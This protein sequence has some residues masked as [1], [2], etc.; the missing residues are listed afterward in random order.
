MDNVSVFT[1]R[2]MQQ[3]LLVTTVRVPGAKDLQVVVGSSHV[4]LVFSMGTTAVSSYAPV[5]LFH[6]R[7]LGQFI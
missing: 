3:F 2:D 5:R 4:T 1:Q 6:A 7:F